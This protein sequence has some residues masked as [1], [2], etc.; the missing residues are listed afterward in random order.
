MKFCEAMDLL[1]AGKKVTRNDWKDGLYFILEE[2]KVHSYQPV[3]EHYAYNEDIMVSE[4]WMVDGA[5][6]SK[7]FCEI[8][9]DLQNGSKA[10]MSDWKPEF[11][12]YLDPQSGLV[13]HRMSQFPFNPSF[14]DF[15]AND[16]IEL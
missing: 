4:N 6:E 5:T 3:V 9:P 14:E 16:W 10:W 8:I 13:L 12:I 11:F 1:K 7:S 2:G 15:K